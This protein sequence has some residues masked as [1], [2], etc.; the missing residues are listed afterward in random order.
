MRQLLTSIGEM[1]SET[2]ALVLSVSK[3]L[4]II[5]DV[6]EGGSTGSGGTVLVF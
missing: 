3:I 5:D 6:T 4:G 1:R 2:R